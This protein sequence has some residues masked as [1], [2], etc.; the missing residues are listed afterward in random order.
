MT[1]HIGIGIH[2]KEDIMNKTLGTSS[3]K[4]YEY[5]AAGLPVLLY[6][7]QQFRNYLGKYKWAFFTDC[8]K[9]SLISALETMERNIQELGKRG[10]DGF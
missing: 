7:N 1:Y 4:I 10:Q 9:A 8:S 3:N 6:D 5:A 2:R